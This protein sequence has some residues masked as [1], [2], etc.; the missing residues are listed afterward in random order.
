MDGVSCVGPTFCIAIGDRNKRWNGKTWSNIPNSGG[1]AVSCVSPTNCLVV[2][3]TSA[4][5]WNGKG[6]TPI[7]GP[8]PDGGLV[9][10]SCL[11]TS[12]C[13]AVGSYLTP[14]GANTLVER[15]S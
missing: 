10:V 7:A 5:Q 12:V 13:F 1:G 8:E 4:A 6:W 11:R 2:G 14:L 9:G 3:G 15:A